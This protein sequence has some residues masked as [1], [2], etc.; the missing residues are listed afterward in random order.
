MKRVLKVRQ[1]SY[2][3]KILERTGLEDSKPV[4]TPVECQIDS[5]TL[6]SDL[7]C[8]TKYCQAIEGLT[9]YMSCT[10]PDIAFA[11]GRHFQHMDHPAAGLWTFVKRAL[12][13]I[14]GTVDERI[15]LKGEHVVL[16]VR[17]FCVENWAGC[18][19]DKKPTRR[20]VVTV[21][22]AAVS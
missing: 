15:M 3:L 16:D 11:V 10:R 17:R 20:I 8:R 2:A 13:C 12:R 4:S 5:N 22:R 19:L 9:Y 6:G 1:T 18:K 21:A 7:F 14:K